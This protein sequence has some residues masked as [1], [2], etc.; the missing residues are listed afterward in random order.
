[1]INLYTLIYFLISLAACGLGVVMW[2]LPCSNNDE[3]VT[4]VVA[5]I[6]CGFV[7]LVFFVLYLMQIGVVVK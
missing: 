7:S 4:C 5:T 2:R 6:I 3:Q 1:M